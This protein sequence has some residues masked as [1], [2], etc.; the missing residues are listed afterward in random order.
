M[1]KKQEISLEVRA[2]I[3]AGYSAGVPIKELAKMH[4]CHKNSVLYQ[5]KKAK[6][7][8]NLKNVKGRGRK[9]ATTTKED[10]R[11]VKLLKRNP[12]ERLKSIQNDI[13][14]VRQTNISLTTIRRRLHEANV[15]AYTIKKKP[16][17]NKRNKQ[18]RLQFA[19][20]YLSKPVEFWRNVLWTDESSFCLD[21]TYG[22]KFYY[23][24]AKEKNSRSVIMPTR[25]SGGG[26]VMIWGCFSYN[27]VGDLILLPQKVTSS[28]YLHILNE[29]ALVSG[30]QGIGTHFILQQDNAPI[31]K[32]RMIAKYL[33]DLDQET[34]DWPPQSPDLNPL[35][36][37]WHYLKQNMT[38]DIGRQSSET[39]AEIKNI[40]DQIPK[41]ILE[42]LVNSI[43]DRLQ[44]VIDNNGGNTSY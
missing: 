2:A 29:N 20:T 25:H 36:N 4:N 30:C 43:P 10:N 11:I 21:G 44:E 6:L 41:E 15:K 8:K 18:K 12:Q 27:G 39:F 34:I 31:H 28:T 24:T 22:K 38:I 13:N 37:L 3:V 33:R 26:K 23:S 14:N 42:N 35:E 5:I 16:F 17:I 9:R 32:S 1:V 19:R 7:Q 40:W